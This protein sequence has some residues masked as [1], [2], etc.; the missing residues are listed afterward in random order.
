M[1]TYMA[2]T[3]AIISLCIIERK[4]T[5]PTCLDVQA[6]SGKRHASFW[7]SHLPCNNASV[8]LEALNDLKCSFSVNYIWNLI[9]LIT[10]FNDVS[11]DFSFRDK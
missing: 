11:I 6:W 5:T 8:I 7:Y 10:Y 4:F 9:K 3:N 1:H 2:K